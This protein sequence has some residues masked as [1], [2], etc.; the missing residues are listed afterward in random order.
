MVLSPLPIDAVVADVVRAAREA[1]SVV[2]EAP[3]GAGKTTRLPPA[4]LALDDSEVLVL[5][6]RRLAT[7]LAAKRVAAE[8]GEMLGETVGYQVRFDEV[9]GPRTRLRFLTEGVLTRRLLRDPELRG[10]GTVVL[11]E[12]HERHLDG[13]AALALLRELQLSR[14]PELRLVVMSATLEAAPVARYLGDCPVVRSEGRLFPLDIRYTPHSARSLED[15]VSDA[16]TSA[17]RERDTGD[18]LVFLPGAAE[19]RRCQRALAG[20]RQIEVLPLHGDLSPEEQDRAVAPG[21]TRKVILSTNVAESSVTIEGVRIVIDSGLARIASDSPYTGLAT[22]KIGRISQSSATQRAGRAGRMGP[23]LVIRLYSAEEYHRRPKFDVPE[24]ERRE[25]SGLIL[26]LKLMGLEP[27]ALP[28]FEPPPEAAV[29][30]AYELLTRLGALDQGGAV[31]STGREMA[32]LPLTPRLARLLVEAQ[33]R[34]AGQTGCAVAAVLSADERLPQGLHRDDSSDL[35]A[36]AEGQLS[37]AA[38]A[39]LRQIKRLIKPAAVDREPEQGVLWATLAAYPDRVAKRRGS[40]LLL[41]SGGAAVQAES[42]VVRSAPFVVAVDIEHRHEQKQPIV[43]LA[44]RIEPEWL[45]DLF[46]ERVTERTSVEWNR[47]DERV[48]AVSS[49]L[50]EGLT[51]EESRAQAPAEEAAKLLAAKAREAGAERFV[52]LEDLD[53][54]LARA[55]FARQHTGIGELGEEEIRAAWESLCYGLRSFR[56]LQNAAKE[57]GLLT[58]IVQQLPPADQRKLEEAA[59]TRLKLPSGRQA[60]IHYAAGQTPSVASR[61]QDFFGLRQSPAI[62]NGRVPLVVHLLAPNQRP[63][64]MTTDLAGFWERLY[65]QVRRELGRRYPRHSWPEDPLQP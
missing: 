61:L 24:I 53:E 21:A 2:V 11:D 26:G 36:L 42:S 51:I 35:L 5:E 3:P 28:W 6:P 33:R 63:V 56:E 10:V 64:Q 57:G 60:K 39:T 65:P 1:R 15:Q 40:E 20:L 46:P 19:I 48:E 47:Q 25:L 13:D 7:R 29:A 43:R 16:V 8:L 27:C 52:A 34:G 62:A 38:Q 44:S 18:V 9:G 37:G 31:T 30:S 32:R 4:L 49:L 45:L 55:A 50:Y 41:A 22:T 54:L 12:F 14:R 17:L 59:P 58:A 23:G